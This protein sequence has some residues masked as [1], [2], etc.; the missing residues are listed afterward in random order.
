MTFEIGYTFVTETSAINKN[1]ESSLEIK[2]T[3]E[4]LSILGSGGFGQV[5]Q[6][7]HAKNNDE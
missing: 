6:V 3:F 1:V 4:T 5:Y 7:K 2:A